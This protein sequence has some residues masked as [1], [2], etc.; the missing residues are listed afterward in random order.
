MQKDPAAHLVPVDRCAVF[1]Q[2]EASCSPPKA[3]VAIPQMSGQDVLQA[4]A[5][6]AVPQGT[7]HSAF[8][9]PSRPGLAE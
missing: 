7:K 4:G 8:Q 1:R 3:N 2:P 6:D 9:L 5:Q